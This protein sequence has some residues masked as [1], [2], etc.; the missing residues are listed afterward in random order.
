VAAGCAATRIPASE[1]VSYVVPELN[2]WLRHGYAVVRTDYEGL[3][4]PGGAFPT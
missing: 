1:S 4:V 2:S 3:G